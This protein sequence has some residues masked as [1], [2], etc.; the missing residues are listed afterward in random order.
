MLDA[1][2]RPLAEDPE[3]WAQALGVSRDAVA[4]MAAS[5]VID[6]HVDSFIWT[7]VFGYDIGKRHRPGLAPGCFWNQVDLPRLRNVGVTGATWVITTNPL[8][9][10]RG[11]ARALGQNLVRLRALLA[12]QPDVRV[13]RTVAEYREARQAGRHAA[14][15]GIQGGNALDAQRDLGELLGQGWLLRVTLM[16]LSTSRLGQTSAPLRFGATGLTRHGHEVVQALN[17]ARVFV[18]LAHINRAGFF[19]ALRAH[20]RSLPAI[21]THTGVSGVHPHWRNL[22]DEQLRAIAAT[23]GT[24]GIMY[25]SGYLGDPIFGGR[26]SSIVAHLQHVIDVVGEDHASLGSDWD[27]FIVTPRDMPTCS[28][29]PRLVQGMLERG[30]SEPRIQ[31]VLGGNFLRCL[32]ALRG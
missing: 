29:L 9:S 10:A 12:A 17:A 4:L 13:V 16:H 27:G 22:D 25:H 1:E 2:A 11:R 14:F 3:A 6:L 8:R 18:D 15:L 31:K 28:E 21:V 19:D 26:A 7:R 32:A 24:I 20:D 5:D 23:G 30:W